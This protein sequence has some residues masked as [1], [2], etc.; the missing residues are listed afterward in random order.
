MDSVTSGS[1]PALGMCLSQASE[2]WSSQ[3]VALCSV[4]GQLGPLLPGP[5]GEDTREAS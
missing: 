5:P 1:L 3:D 2:V 4:S